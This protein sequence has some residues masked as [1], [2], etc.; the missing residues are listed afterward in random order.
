MIKINKMNKNTTR[1][2]LSKYFENSGTNQYTAVMPI[3]VD[4]EYGISDIVIE[5]SETSQKT[6]NIIINFLF[7]EPANYFWQKNNIKFF[8]DL[9][10]DNI[11]VNIGTV[12]N[13]DYVFDSEDGFLSMYSQVFSDNS[14]EISYK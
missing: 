8:G 13:M 4:V 12:I 2:I 3:D 14:I 5:F 7:E 6:L 11:P 1:K 9:Y 10:I